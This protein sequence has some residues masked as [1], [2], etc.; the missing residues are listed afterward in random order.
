MSTILQSGCECLLLLQHPWMA[1]NGV[2]SDAP[3]E[4]E[5]Q[6]RLQK[7]QVLNKLKRQA[8]KL[9]ATYM[10]PEEVCGM[11]NQFQA[12]DKDGNGRPPCLA[13]CTGEYA[14]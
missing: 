9:I 12:L 14:W 5:I 3:L 6:Q 10:P 1:E 11:R 2:A 7:F 8:L 13:T 4:N